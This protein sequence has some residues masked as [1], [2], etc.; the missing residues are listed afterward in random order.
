MKKYI[1]KLEYTVRVPEGRTHT[2][3]IEAEDEESA[4]RQAWDEVYDLEGCDEFDL[5]EDR[6]TASLAPQRGGEDDKTIDMFQRGS[7]D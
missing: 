6:E 3:T 2:A 1:V 7:E 4:I 5:D